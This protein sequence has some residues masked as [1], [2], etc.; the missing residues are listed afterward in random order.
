MRYESAELA[1]I[2]INFCL[3]AS[4]SVAN[5]LAEVS[6]AIGADWAEIVPALK[7]D[8]RI[9]PDAY[10]TPGLGI[11]GGNLERDVRT[12]LDIAA[13][14]GTDAGLMEAWLATSRHRKEWCW[15]TLQSRVLVRQPDAPI[16]VLGLAYKENTDSTKNSPAL[17]LLRH[18]EGRDVRVHDPVVPGAVVP[19]ARACAEPLACAKGAAALVVATPWPQYRALAIADLAAAMSGRVL[20]DPY[21]MLDGA[22]AVCAGFEYHALGVPP[23]VPA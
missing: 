13:A 21:R 8:P 9:G 22:A 12:V 16:A 14:K 17:A 2:S 4:V 19:F 7:L 3:V 11:S 10:L 23:L 5:T 20:I 15:R 18:L 1:K 6:E